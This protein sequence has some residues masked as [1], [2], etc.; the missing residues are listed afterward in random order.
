M[1]GTHN[2]HLMI[3]T[4]NGTQKT[5]TVRPTY[6]NQSTESFVI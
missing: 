6:N 3:K 5:S 4:E 2:T 1:G